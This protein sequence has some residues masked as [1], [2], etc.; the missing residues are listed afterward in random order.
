MF[1]AKYF[2]TEKVEYNN[3]PLR[4][5]QLP[6]SGL[7]S[8]HKVSSPPRNNIDSYIMFC[9]KD[10]WVFQ[11]I[12]ATDNYYGLENGRFDRVMVESDNALEAADVAGTDMDI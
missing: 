3:E 1:F 7:I 11:R 8:A 12:I 6:T 2:W 9:D 10:Q 5:V 4:T